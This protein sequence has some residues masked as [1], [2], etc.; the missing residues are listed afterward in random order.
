MLSLT[1]TDI[2]FSEEADARAYEVEI[3]VERLQ[4]KPHP[5]GPLIAITER[6]KAASGNEQEGRASVMSHI[7]GG[8]I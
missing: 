6:I 8:E 5:M 3:P 7:F 2:R 4:G 1:A